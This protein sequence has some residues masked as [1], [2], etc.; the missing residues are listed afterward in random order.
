M[1]FVLA[2]PSAATTEHSDRAMRP[3]FGGKCACF[4][5]KTARALPGR[6]AVP[7]A[8]TD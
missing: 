3:G 4:H 8:M 6:C 7:N 5:N 2:G 1:D